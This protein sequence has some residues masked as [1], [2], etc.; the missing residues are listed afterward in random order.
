MSSL[1]AS[2]SYK[3]KTT[4]AV[5]A[6]SFLL[7][8]ALPAIAG[9]GPDLFLIN[10][11]HLMV[12][13]PG[14]SF[15]YQL[16]FRNNGTS[17]ATG[18]V[19]R[20]TVPEGTTFDAVASTPGWSCADGAPAGT[21][22]EIS[23]PDLDP[24]VPGGAAVFFVRVDTALPAGFDLITNTAEIFDDGT[25]GPELNPADNVATHTTPVDVSGLAPDL[26]VAKDDGGVSTAPSGLVVYTLSYA[27]I[28]TRGATGAELAD[29]VPAFTVFDAGSSSG[30]WSCADGAPPGT[31][32]QLSIGTLQPGDGGS[33]PF[34]VRVDAT[35]P[36]G[37]DP[38]DNQA[39]IADDGANGADLDPSNNTASDSTPFGGPG[40]G[41]DL[42]VTKDDAGITANLGDTVTYQ[43]DYSNLGPR[44]A[45][46]VEL[47]ETVPDHAT[48]DDAASTPG[49]SCSP[50]APAG[51]PCTLSVGT[52]A[53]GD[54]GVATFAATVDAAVPPGTSEISNTVEIVDDGTNGA[55]VDPSN[56]TAADST[57]L[58]LPPGEAELEATAID[59]PA[60]GVP[61]APGDIVSYTVVVTN[62]GDDL[63]RRVEI[64]GHPPA[65]TAFRAG[66]VTTT[67]GGVAQGNDPGD[68][69]VLVAVGKLP[70]GEEAV[71]TFEVAIDRPLPQ[72][73]TEIAFQG[74]AR[75][76]N[77]I[78]IVTD[79]PDTQTPND[80]TRTPVARELSPVEI[81]TAG[82]LA[83]VSLAGLLS[84][85]AVFRL[86][87]VSA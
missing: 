11:D 77:R 50:G 37:A 35:L 41:P 86:R 8:H 72:A 63:A 27:N 13:Q 71:V 66:T 18:V 43:L 7:A 75:A 87:T 67:H 1:C 34:A 54:A 17:L 59:T 82:T 56:N 39:A 16:V 48:F 30:A 46:G 52:L 58:V 73:V 10:E 69:R 25:H 31:V 4:V 45:T 29:T 15:F 74:T 47:Q 6:V 57:P 68:T 26:R 53:T 32:C 76:A 38:L 83:L 78:A 12:A 9:K 2:L 22:C 79:D 85:A 42:A 65:D 19:V 60:S 61:A 21:V 80:P 49:W 24:G 20:D 23:G 36:P 14:Q 84:L 28:G 81:P 5:L 3:S 44:G 55:E 33:V 62:T 70:V 51:T 40:A 64:E